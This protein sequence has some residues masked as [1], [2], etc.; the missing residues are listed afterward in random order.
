MNHIEKEIRRVIEETVNP[1]LD[2]HLGGAVL[3]SFSDGTAR[4]RFTGSCQNCY[5]AEDTLNSVIKSILMEQI[6]EVKDVVLDDS[7]SEE[8]LDFARKLL[9]S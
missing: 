6:P 8:L 5:S 1:I 4:I 7:I 9:K 2:Q 3:S